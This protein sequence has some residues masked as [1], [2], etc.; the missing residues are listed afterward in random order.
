MQYLIP[1]EPKGVPQIEVTLDVNKYCILN[2]SAQIKSTGKVKKI[3]IWN[4][5]RNHSQANIN[6]VFA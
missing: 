6:N 5:M 4:E 3:T 2:V 1:P